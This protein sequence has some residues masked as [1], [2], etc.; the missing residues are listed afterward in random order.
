MLQTKNETIPAQ[1]FDK[2]KGLAGNVAAQATDKEVQ[3]MLYL[4]KEKR[5]LIING[6]DLQSNSH[7]ED[8]LMDE[9]GEIFACGLEE[10]RLRL[11]EHIKESEKTSDSPSSIDILDDENILLGDL[12]K[13]AKKYSFSH[14]KVGFTTHFVN[15]FFTKKEAEDYLKRY[16]HKFVDSF[17]ETMNMGESNPGMSLIFA[18]LA[19]LTQEKEGVMP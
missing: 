1:I 13:V 6:E 2:I 19:S 17:V 5:W 9:E 18:F 11:L 4:L 8:G 7:L 12:V 16:G 15:C 10:S 14:I 3:P